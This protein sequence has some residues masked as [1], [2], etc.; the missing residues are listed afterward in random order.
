[1]CSVHASASSSVLGKREMEREPAPDYSRGIGM[2]ERG[3]TP[4]PRP[5]EGCPYGLEGWVLFVEGVGLLVGVGGVENCGFG[6][7][8]A[9]ELESDG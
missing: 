4:T 6:E 1:M 9:G 3:Q 2:G 5:R 8:A 7:V